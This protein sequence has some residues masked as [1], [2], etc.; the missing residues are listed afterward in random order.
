MDPALET[1]DAYLTAIGGAAAAGAS[2]GAVSG[3][4]A[5]RATR[6]PQPSSAFFGRAAEAAALASAISDPG[7]VTVA[8]PGGVGKT[9]LVTQVA[10]TTATWAALSGGR[11]WVSLAV[12]TRDE[13]VAAETAMAL[14]LPVGTDDAATLIAA[15]LAPL[16]RAM[17]VLDGCEA[18]LD[19][20]ASLAA[21]L[22]AACPAL[23]LVVTSRVP[24]AVEAERVITIAAFPSPRPGT[25]RELAATDQ[26]RL[27]VDR[28]RRSGW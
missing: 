18:I 25:W 4:K 9:R 13:L 14:G 3:G 26:V 8:G 20:A 1:I 2:G 22:L 15:H 16:G 23:T 28:V 17:L 12:V 21:T 5:G 7:L 27:L 11:L 10:R 24:L 6:V 19:G